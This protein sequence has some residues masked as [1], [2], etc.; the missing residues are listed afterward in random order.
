MIDKTINYGVSVWAYSNSYGNAIK[1]KRSYI[2]GL[3]VFLC[4]VTPFTNWLIPFSG[5]IIKKDKW[6]RY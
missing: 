6:L 2:I 3:I 1:L 5:K 4:I